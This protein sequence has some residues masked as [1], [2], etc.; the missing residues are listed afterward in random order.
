MPVGAWRCLGH[1]TKRVRRLV[2]VAVLSRLGVGRR[3]R[4][5]TRLVVGLALVLVAVVGGLRLAAAADDTVAV[6][7]A[8]RDLPANHVLQASDLRV[9]RVRASGGVLDGLVRATDLVDARGRVLLYPLRADGLLTSAGL[10]AAPSEGREITVPVTPEHALGGRI[11]PGDRVDVLGSFDEAGRTA[12]TLTVARGAEVVELVRA[13]GLFGQREGEL[14]ALTLSVTADDAVPLAFAIRNA[15][16]DI[17]RTSGAERTGRS[18]F[19]ATE[20]P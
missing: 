11:Q 16:L 10:V 7:A 2:T 12:R 20:L 17:V 9:A 14:S 4:V 6:L 1:R 19:D 8:A 3:L 18:S 15:E 13:E 5:D